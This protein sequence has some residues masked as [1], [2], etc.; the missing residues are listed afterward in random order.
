MLRL[1][2]LL[3]GALV[4]SVPLPGQDVGYQVVV[5]KSNAV[6]RLTRDQVSRIFLRQLTFWENR[7]H[8]LPVDQRPDS[9]ARRTFTQQIH[10][11]TIASVQTWWQQQIFTGGEVPPPERASD[12]DVLDYVRKYPSAI[13]YIRAGVPVGADLKIVAVTP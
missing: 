9:P 6:N 13:G 4:L 2:V 1:A 10:H 8:V 12:S 3:A 7:Q 11:R 5:H